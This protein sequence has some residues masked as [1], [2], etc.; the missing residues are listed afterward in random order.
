M[1]LTYQSTSASVLVCSR[2]MH[3]TTTSWT[4]KIRNGYIITLIECLARATCT[5]I[6]VGSPAPRVDPIRSDARQPKTHSWLVDRRGPTPFAVYHTSTR[7]KDNQEAVHFSHTNNMC[8]ERYMDYTTYICSCLGKCNVCV[9]K[10]SEAPHCMSTKC[11]YLN[12]IFT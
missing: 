11:W 2:N 10:E 3:T 6:A 8:Q 12:S 9:H 5:S 4:L 1:S 7:T